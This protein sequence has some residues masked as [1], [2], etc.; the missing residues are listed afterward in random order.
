M[1]TM[2]KWIQ[3]RISPGM[4][5]D[6]RTVEVDDRAFFV[7]KASVREEGDGNGCVEVKVVEVDGQKWAVMPT[8]TRESIP[9]R[10]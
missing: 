1:E 9:L 10:A 4:F 5:S 7:N 6:E 3:C 2:S 8:S